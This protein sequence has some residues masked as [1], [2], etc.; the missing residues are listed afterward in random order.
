MLIL[1]DL[2]I[3]TCVFLRFRVMK[4]MY[5]EWVQILYRQEDSLEQEQ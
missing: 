2:R 4:K 3:K 5:L 1:R